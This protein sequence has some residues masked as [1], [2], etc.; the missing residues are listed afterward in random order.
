MIEMY[1]VNPCEGIAF[2]CSLFRFT[3]SLHDFYA[4]LPLT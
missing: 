2:G 1:L 4:T 3:G